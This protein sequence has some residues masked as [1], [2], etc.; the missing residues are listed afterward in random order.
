MQNVVGKNMTEMYQTKYYNVRK[1]Y[2]IVVKCYV[3]PKDTAE[4]FDEFWG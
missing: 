1:Y 2:E 4:I 3:I